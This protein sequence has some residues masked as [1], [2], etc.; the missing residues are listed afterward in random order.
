MSRNNGEDGRSAS[1]LGDLRV[2]GPVE[3]RKNVLMSKVGV[4]FDTA[5]S[6]LNVMSGGSWSRMSESV[7]GGGSLM[8]GSG[9]K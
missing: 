8:P 5:G 2:S 9:A 7:K 6:V 1:S 3:S 4:A